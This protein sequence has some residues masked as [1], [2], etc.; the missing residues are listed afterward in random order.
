MLSEVHIVGV[1]SIV[2]K[3][4]L[5]KLYK[6]ETMIRV[7]ACML[8]AT[9]KPRV[10][11]RS[12]RPVTACNHR[13]SQ[14]HFSR[15]ASLGSGYYRHGDNGR[16]RSEKGTLRMRL[17]SGQKFRNAHFLMTRVRFLVPIAVGNT[18]ADFINGTCV[19]GCQATGTNVE[20][21]R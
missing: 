12:R 2:V 3:Y 11:A 16:D 6:M 1:D 9:S 4:K 8:P 19:L 21:I 20:S 5:K 13:L 10:D 7:R 18:S 15:P 14:S 17:S